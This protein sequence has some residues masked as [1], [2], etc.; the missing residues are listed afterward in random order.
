MLDRVP[1]EALTGAMLS[2][3]LAEQGFVRLS[4]GD[5]LDRLGSDAR[6][7]WSSFA[8]SW[9]DLLKVGP[10]SCR[11]RPKAVEPAS[12]P[13]GPRTRSPPVR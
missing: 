13:I 1:A 7:S 8:K 10:A 2:S 11:A 3:M 9:D 4:A 6:A 5:L 12:T